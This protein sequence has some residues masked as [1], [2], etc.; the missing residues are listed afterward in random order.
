MRSLRSFTLTLNSLC[1]DWHDSPCMDRELAEEKEKKDIAHCK[2][3]GPRSQ[4]NELFTWIPKDGEKFL[5]YN[6][7][8]GR[9]S[10]HMYSLANAISFAAQLNR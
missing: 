10:N 9:Q 1:V 5:G 3:T 4:S 8:F 7:H 6:Y 2:V